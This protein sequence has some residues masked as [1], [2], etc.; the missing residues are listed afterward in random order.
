[1]DWSSLY[2]LVSDAAKIPLLA[3]VA[4]GL[5]G[6]ALGSICTHSF[7]QKREREKLL[8]EKAEAL[9]FDLYQTD[10]RLTIWR[11]AIGRQAGHTTPARVVYPD[12]LLLDLNQVYALQRLY[13]PALQRRLETMVD[14]LMPFVGWLETQWDQQDRDFESWSAQF[15]PGEADPL[16]AT[17]G[18]ALE[19][20]IEAVVRA[21]PHSRTFARELA[22]HHRHR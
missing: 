6:G 20:T 10:H 3:A 12:T 15:C 9:I 7:T 21:V 11:L 2:D 16:Y 1:M 22:R 8:R 18:T 13:F 17:Y 14:A 5:I 4:G 19:E